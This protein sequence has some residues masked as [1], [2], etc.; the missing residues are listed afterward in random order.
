MHFCWEIE[1]MGW[2]V[3]LSWLECLPTSHETEYSKP[4]AS[5]GY[6]RQGLKN[7]TLTHLKHQTKEWDHK[8][9]S[10]VYWSSVDS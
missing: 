1:I 2:G 9:A 8:A 10:E 5:L 7:I 4:E 3:W 6:M